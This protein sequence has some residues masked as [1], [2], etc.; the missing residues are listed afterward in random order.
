[1][2]RRSILGRGPNATHPG[3]IMIGTTLWTNVSAPGPG[4]WIVARTVE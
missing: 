4:W 2:V 1:M 3:T